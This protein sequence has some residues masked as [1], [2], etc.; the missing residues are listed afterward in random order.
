[1]QTGI[2]NSEVKYIKEKPKGIGN[3][4]TLPQ[5]ISEVQKLEEILLALTEQVTYRLRK[6]NL[7]AKTVNVQLRTKDFEDFSHQ[8]K[9][10]SATS[11]TKEILKSAKS[12][13]MEMFKQGMFIRLIGVRVDNLVS[14]DEMQISL[15]GDSEDEKKQKKLDSVIDSLNE[16]YGYDSIVR[17]GKLNSGYIYDNKISRKN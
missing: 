4:T 12:L 10:Y 5:N 6:Y 3:S 9:L 7:L 16:K 17:A 15:F 11:S 14:K 8:S 1:M 13:L 2:D